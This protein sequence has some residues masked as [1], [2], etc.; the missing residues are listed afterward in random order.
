MF[1]A[2]AVKKVTD[3]VLE[4]ATTIALI[5]E[6]KSNKKKYAYWMALA[7]KMVIL[8]QGDDACSHTTKLFGEYAEVVYK[9]RY[10]EK[11][12]FF[13]CVDYQEFARAMVKE[14]VEIGNTYQN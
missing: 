7:Q 2:V 11:A 8:D 10:S 5:K 3:T 9:D 13:Y 1:I 6:V 14:L 12:G 4:K